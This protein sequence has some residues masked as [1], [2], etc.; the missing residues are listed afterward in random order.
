MKKEKFKIITE[1]DDDQEENK[2]DN[3][4][5]LNKKKD[6]GGETIVEEIKEVISKTIPT[7][8]L[9]EI[10]DESLKKIN[11]TKETI[12][13]KIKEIPQYLDSEQI[14]YELKA[15]N[16]NESKKNGLF[17]RGCNCDCILF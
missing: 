8:T 12:K 5:M 3:N 16:A 17:N 7:E 14:P 9:K 11:E 10:T 6:N 1:D 4:N 13:E 15:K 2:N